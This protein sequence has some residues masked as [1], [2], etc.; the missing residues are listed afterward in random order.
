MIRRL[1]HWF[2][3]RRKRGTD[4]RCGNCRYFMDLSNPDDPPDEA[5]GYCE[6]PFHS[7]WWSPHR[8]YGG[9]WTHHSTWCDI[10]EPTSPQERG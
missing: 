6:H 8:K 10:Y 3:G 9:H 4:E 5:D 7:T 2:G 1:L